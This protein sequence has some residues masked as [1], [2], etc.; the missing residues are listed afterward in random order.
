MHLK[1][2]E[3]AG[4][5]SFAKKTA[6]DFDNPIVAIVGP[7][8]SGKSNVAEAVRFVL[9]EQ[10][11]KSMRGKRGEDLIWNGSSSTPRMN[12]AAVSLTFDN[13]TRFLD[14]DFDEVAVEREVHRDGTSDYRINGSVV[15]LKD[16]L[17]L[18]ASANIGQSGHHIISQGEADK[19]LSASPKE[20]REMLEDA[21]GLKVY[22]FKLE[23]SKRKLAKTEENMRQVEALRREVAPHLKFLKRQVDKLKKAE[24][25]RREAATRFRTFFMHEEARLLAE[26]A[27][28]DQKHQVNA[29]KLTD[30]RGRIKDART[31]LAGNAESE[32]SEKILSLSE[33]LDEAR[34]KRRA[35]AAAAARLA[36]QLEALTHETDVGAP[37]PS[38][39]LSALIKKKENEFSAL[40]GSFEAM[41]SF[42][43]SFLGELKR[44]ISRGGESTGSTAKLK[45]E[46]AAAEDEERALGKKEAALAAELE[47][48]R[49]ALD[50]ARSEERERERAL[51]TLSTD[52]RELAHEE[53]QIQAERERLRLEEEEDKRERGEVGILIGREAV[54]YDR[55]DAGP[56][57]REAQEKEKR[58]LQKLKVRLEDAGGAGGEEVMKEYEEVSEREAFLERELTDLQSSAASLKELITELNEELSSRFKDGISAI[59]E[60]FSRFFAL[61]FDGGTAKLVS[62]KEPARRIRS[63]EDEND[64]GV[65][66]E[67]EKPV[68][69]IDLSLSIPRKRIKSLVM[70][71]GGERALTSIALIFAMSSVNPPPFLVLDE[72]DAALDEANSRR[73][74]DMVA[75]LSKKSQLILITHNR[76]TMSRAGILY[77]VTMGGDGVSKVLSVKLEEAVQVAK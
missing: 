29:Q 14:I 10:S 5:K 24:D 22:Q 28:L 32:H 50:E 63:L 76:E 35:A 49:A 37:I 67:L 71:S 43:E 48:L 27:R 40:D 25:L 9:G 60:E 12:R 66:D 15:R 38:T 74:G 3:L 21:L 65:P 45:E 39:E 31:A 64:D 52:E 69:G 42:A 34:E 46:H 19:I 54:T 72:T 1:K 77:G 57:S 56:P 70:L 11:M 8:G 36:G 73:Y 6:F 61:M 18:M 16:I 33:A 44:L 17:S 23:E 55:Q 4:F 30:V 51:F 59:N 26:R 7:N 20:R 13:R 62:V 68:E 41:R 58:E 47:T 53:A 75:A 2:F